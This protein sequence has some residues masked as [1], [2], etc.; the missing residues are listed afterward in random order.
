MEYLGLASNN[1]SEW[2]DIEPLLN[3]IGKRRIE[4]EELV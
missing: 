4:G 1:L 3:Y 2:E